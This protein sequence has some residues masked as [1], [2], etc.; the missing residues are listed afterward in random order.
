MEN[1]SYFKESPAHR[2][3]TEDR[4][5]RQDGLLRSLRQ[6]QTSGCSPLTSPWMAAA[7]DIQARSGETGTRVRQAQ[8]PREHSGTAFP[9]E[10]LWHRPPSHWG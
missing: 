3:R 2:S 10:Q 5:Q 6:E 1:G 9:G 7:A 4:E 8:C